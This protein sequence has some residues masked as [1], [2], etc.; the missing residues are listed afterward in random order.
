VVPGFGAITAL[1]NKR[2]GSA[3]LITPPSNYGYGV[4]AVAEPSLDPKSGWG[5]VLSADEL[6]LIS[7]TKGSRANS[8]I[9]TEYIQKAAASANPVAVTQADRYVKPFYLDPD[10]QTGRMRIY[11]AVPKIAAL[12]DSLARTHGMRS[13]IL[14]DVLGY[15]NTDGGLQDPLV[16]R[17]GGTGKPWTADSPGRLMRTRSL[18]FHC[19]TLINSSYDNAGRMQGGLLA[20]V[21]IS[22]PPGYVQTWA[23]QY[24]NSMPTAI[25]GGA[26]DSIQFYLTNQDGESVH[27]G[28]QTFQAT[29]RLFWDD[30]V[31]PQI[32]SAGA[33]AESAFGLRD[34][35]YAR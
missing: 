35:M 7:E 20:D 29:L 2:V 15:S 34:V 27:N 1:T 13:S 11:L 6:R 24:D 8:I 4:K 25:H 3:I 10:P 16:N 26:I 33:E 30:P 18:Q 28:G 23:A 5:Q 14:K 31:P 19:P 17:P 32:G 12:D 21:P 22:V 9:P